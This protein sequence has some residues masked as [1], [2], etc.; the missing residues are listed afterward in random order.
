MSATSPKNI[1]LALLNE[2]DSVQDVTSLY[3]LVE[4]IERTL[5]AHDFSQCPEICIA[6]HYCA[7]RALLRVNIERS[8]E[9]L[10]PILAHS[11]AGIAWLTHIDLVQLRSEFVQLRAEAYIQV[12]R[13]LTPEQL[14]DAVQACKD[15]L[16][17]PGIQVDPHRCGPLAYN[18]GIFVIRREGFPEN[19]EHNLLEA[20][21]KTAYE[22]YRVTGLLRQ[23]ADA[24]L[25]LSQIGL[26]R[27]RAAQEP[28]DQAQRTF[29]AAWRQINEFMA[30]YDPL[31]N[32]DAWAK[33]N[34]VA[35]SLAELRPAADAIERARDSMIYLDRAFD[36]FQ[37]LHNEEGTVDCASRL[38]R[39]ME[40]LQPGY[41]EGAAVRFGFYMDVLDAARERSGDML[42]RAQTQLLRANAWMKVGRGLSPEHDADILSHVRLHAQLA[43]S[44]AAE[45]DEHELSSVAYKLVGG[46]LIGDAGFIRLNR[47]G[48]EPEIDQDSLAE[49]CEAFERSIAEA[50][51]A[52]SAELAAPSVRMLAVALWRRLRDF[53]EFHLFDRCI[54][55]LEEAIGLSSGEPYVAANAN[56]V[57]IMI[58]A[59]Q[60][61]RNVSFGR[62]RQALDCALRELNVL[63]S[64]ATSE[65]V[66]SLEGV[67]DELQFLGRDG[68]DTVARR[69]HAQIAAHRDIV[70]PERVY[71]KHFRHDIFQL[72]DK[73]EPIDVVSLL[74]IPE[75]DDRS[76]GVMHLETESTSTFGIADIA[77]PRCRVMQEITLPVV[78]NEDV[79]SSRLF[80]LKRNA[81]GEVRCTACNLPLQVQSIFT[82]LRPSFSEDP[83]A[84]YPD[85]LVDR[86]DRL[87]A[88]QQYV[89]AG[90]YQAFTGQSLRNWTAIPWSGC[91]GFSLDETQQSQRK[92]ALTLLASGIVAMSAPSMLEA[93]RTIMR[94]QAADSPTSSEIDAAIKKLPL[95]LD[96]LQRR[97][98]LGMIV[99]LMEAARLHSPEWATDQITTS[100][101]LVQHSASA[102]ASSS[103]LAGDPVERR[104][105]LARFISELPDYSPDRADA[106][107][108]QLLRGPSL[109]LRKLEDDRIPELDPIRYQIALA[110]MKEIR[111]FV[112]QKIAEDK[113]ACSSSGAKA[114]IA[115]RLVGKAKFT[116][117]LRAFSLDVTIQEAP[118]SLAAAVDVPADPR[119]KWRMF[120]FDPQ[121]AHLV[122]RT[123]TALPQDVNPLTVLN[124]LDPMPPTLPTKLF[125]T[126]VEWRK[127]A[128]SLI[129]EAAV[130]ILLLPAGSTLGNAGVD[131]EIQTIRE[132]SRQD[133][134]IAIITRPKEVGF[135]FFM[136][137]T[138][139]EPINDTAAE[140]RGLGFQHIFDD[141]AFGTQASSLSRMVRTVF[142][143]Q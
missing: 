25:Y 90:L 61:G 48:E 88:H 31:T 30:T 75:T 55:V 97:R 7:A 84:V 39:A 69:V 5:A 32:L 34:L 45:L 115:S 95:E 57:S 72:P 128:F 87:I 68:L 19:K 120:S 91:T 15:A 113:I 140:L 130:L 94:W 40:Y 102:Y 114:L 119:M 16:A 96:P 49:A 109:E 126:D 28:P 106:L 63:E 127:A 136:N 44:L 122:D 4:K 131:Q 8:V 67:L 121:Q 125:V 51:A 77:C 112:E 53:D 137:S 71:F 50:R 58:L 85:I 9:R 123:C 22:S 107:L 89:I 27:L 99:E 143:S 118:E 66:K 12:S 59:A 60:R 35:A 78:I 41:S 54:A 74:L 36:A 1:G 70:I 62:A 142:N 124:V 98:L 10:A 103:K 6:L 80:A 105:F 33:A 2:A 29:D 17:D 42:A 134:T 110:K 73:A 104:L 92:M 23:A 116:L 81:R 3:G 11:D 21:F 65:Y 138:Q 14:G 13:G 20:L 93:L 111:T 101:S 86:S 108:D 26:N 52:E 133:H 64:I 100:M 132:I 139:T 18:A 56:L 46:S 129:A 83:V 117:I 38:A 135:P 82:F 37:Q 43:V 79:D 47:R 24:S 76:T 141:E